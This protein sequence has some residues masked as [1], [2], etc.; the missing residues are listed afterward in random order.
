M[1]NIKRDHRKYLLA[2]NKKKQ[3]KSFNNVVFY[4]VWDIKLTQ[5][6]LQYLHLN[7]GIVKKHH[8]LLEQECHKLDKLIAQQCALNKTQHGNSTAF[9]RYITKYSTV[10]D[11]IV[12]L[13][14]YHLGTMINCLEND[15]QKKVFDHQRFKL[16]SLYTELKAVEQQLDRLTKYC[17]LPFW[18][19]PVTSNLDDVLKEQGIHTRPTMGGRL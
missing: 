12:R 19:G 9:E 18:S 13:K 8:D 4:P 16:S 5:I 14:E 3:A 6:T 15:P 10:H 2:G 7:L 17:H 11:N 1:E